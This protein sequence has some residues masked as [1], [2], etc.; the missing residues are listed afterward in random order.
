[1][2]PTGESGINLK[3]LLKKRAGV[4]GHRLRIQSTHYR[5]AAWNHPLTR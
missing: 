3:Q 4:P 2:I 1:M 5:F